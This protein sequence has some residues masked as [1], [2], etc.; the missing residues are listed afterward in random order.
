MAKSLDTLLAQINAVISY[1]PVTGD[2]RW[3]ISPRYS[4]LAGDVAGSFD[5]YGYRQIGVAGKVYKAHR[6]AWFLHYGSW[7]SGG[8][9]HINEIKDDNR[10]VNLRLATK[11]Q[12]SY[13]R[14]KP[15]NNS[16]GFKNVS[17]CKRDKRWRSYITCAGKTMSLGYYRTPEAA[18][19]AYCFAA[20][21][22]HGEFANTGAVQ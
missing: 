20:P 15:K 17:Y 10:I 6:V 7:P 14:G 13:N 12:N 2:L 18:Y 1:D 21:R 19:A 4:V 5:V 9:D 11:Q 3:K 8:V 22:H 16:S